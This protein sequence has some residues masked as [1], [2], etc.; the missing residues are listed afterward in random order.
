L[1]VNTNIDEV[2]GLDKFRLID[3]APNEMFVRVTPEY[4]T[5]VEGWKL[6]QAGK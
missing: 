6:T 1:T 2:T 3:D 4:M 5:L